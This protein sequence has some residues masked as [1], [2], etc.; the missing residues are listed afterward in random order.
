MRKI[1]AY[2]FMG[3]IL[4]SGAL[5]IQA[6]LSRLSRIPKTQPM[7][8]R[9]IS[10]F[11]KSATSKTRPSQ[12]PFT[13]VTPRTNQNPFIKSAEQPV[14]QQVGSWF[15]NIQKLYQASPVSSLVTSLAWTAAL[16]L[17]PF[18]IVIIDLDKIMDGLQT[19]RKKI[20]PFLMVPKVP[21]DTKSEQEIKFLSDSDK[22]KQDE[23]AKE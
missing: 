22:N 1:K 20:E 15:Q 23:I 4:L 19:I 3:A 21:V 8:R 16:G 17:L 5:S 11:P 2:I 6:M 7:H 10:T 12:L 13:G 18:G 9:N 14:N